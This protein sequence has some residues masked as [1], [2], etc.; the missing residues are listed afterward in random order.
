MKI[1][2][3]CDHDTGTG[4]RLAGIQDIYTPTTNPQTVLETLSQRTDIGIVFITEIIADQMS[5]QL[6]EFRFSHDT[7]IIVEIPD[8][9][10]YMKD[11]MD[12]VSHL[13]KRAV[14]IDISKKG[15]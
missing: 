6:K 3:I 8:K 2:A 4:L 1:A 11:H 12:F 9:K 10:G 7:P 15:K 13:I 14:G 5:K